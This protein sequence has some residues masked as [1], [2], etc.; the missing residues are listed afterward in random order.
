M[1]QELYIDGIFRDI[2]G[3]QLYPILRELFYILLV[4][5]LIASVFLLSAATVTV[6]L[7]ILRAAGGTALPA[8]G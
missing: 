2:E 3:G 4:Y 6:V 8:P 7:T 1:D 5:L